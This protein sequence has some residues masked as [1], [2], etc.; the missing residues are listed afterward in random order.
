MRRHPKLA[1][2]SAKLAAAEEVLFEVSTYGEELDLEQVW[3]SIE[4]I[5]SRPEL[6]EAVATVTDLVPPP[7]ADDDGEVRARLAERIATVSPFLKILTEVIS[8]GA[9]A[10]AARVL[11]GMPRLLD[12]RKKKVTEA[13][14]DAGLVTGSWKRL[15]FRPGTGGCTVDKNAYVMCVLTQFHRHLKRR[16]IYAEASARWRDPRA[17]LLE[18]DAWQVAKDLALTDLGLP[19][20]PQD[21]LAEHSLL[22][23]L[24]FAGR[25]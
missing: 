6:R 13:D 7:G 24:A 11:T 20:D 4:A 2:A 9:N 8:F 14:I 3:E 18:G 15:V 21:L 17:Q 23:H 12:G 25:R 5:V 1:T 10:E 22:L 19:E 16:D